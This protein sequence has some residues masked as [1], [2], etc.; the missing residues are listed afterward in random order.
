[1]IILTQN[2]NIKTDSNSKVK[3][4]KQTCF[5]AFLKFYIKTIKNSEF[6]QQ[7]QINKVQKKRSCKDGYKGQYFM[8]ND[9]NLADRLFFL[10][11]RKIQTQQNQ[12][13]LIKRLLSGGRGEMH[14]W[15]RKGDIMTNNDRQ[16]VRVGNKTNLLD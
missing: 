10:H 5:L 11:F 1:M 2:L 14:W 9:E 15:H 16:K 8:E 13:R 7:A 6:L 4:L 12:E 3:I